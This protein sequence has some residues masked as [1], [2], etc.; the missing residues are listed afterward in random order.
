MNAVR[1]W[2]SPGPL[3]PRRSIAISPRSVGLQR[4][5]RSPPPWPSRTA[6]SLGYRAMT[7][8]CVVLVEPLSMPHSGLGAIRA[9]PAAPPGGVVAAGSGPRTPPS[10]RQSVRASRA[11]RDLLLAVVR[12]PKSGHNPLSPERGLTVPTSRHTHIRLNLAPHPRARAHA[13]SS[14][15][16]PPPAV[17]RRRS[18][19]RGVRE[20]NRGLRNG[21]GN[22][23]RLRVSG[24]QRGRCTGAAG[25]AAG[26]S[27]TRSPPRGLWHYG[28]LAG[29][30]V[31]DEGP[32]FCQGRRHHHGC[33]PG[34]EFLGGECASGSP[35]IYLP[36]SQR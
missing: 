21:G 20:A 26:V 30:A 23:L 5:P 6:P 25:H 31:V 3:Y 22:S 36:T 7:P 34:A 19:L 18:R 17:P 35:A 15:P 10:T 11:P 29:R 4:P 16:R 8:D 13:S 27:A 28:A 1:F 14:S 32:A 2:G 9:R 33:V 12:R 24:D